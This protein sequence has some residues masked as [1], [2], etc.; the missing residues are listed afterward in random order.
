MSHQI[1]ILY[2]CARYSTH[3]GRYTRTHVSISF[4]SFY[5]QI[6]LNVYYTSCGQS[7]TTNALKRLV[8]DQLE[9][10]N[11]TNWPIKNCFKAFV[12]S[13]W[14]YR[15]HFNEAGATCHALDVWT[16]VYMFRMSHEITERLPRPALAIIQAR[17]CVAYDLSWCTTK[18]LWSSKSLLIGDR[19]FLSETTFVHEV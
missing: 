10:K 15:I 17:A 14:P 3:N 13:R 11:F 12:A 19:S 18:Q 4:Y 8:D 6:F 2:V 1:S 7:L 16:Y 9:K 5:L